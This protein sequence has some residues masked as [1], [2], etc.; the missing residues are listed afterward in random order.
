[1]AAAA[2]AAILGGAQAAGGII[3]SVLNYFNVLH[4]NESNEKIAA[5]NREFQHNEA[6]IDREWQTNMS[7]TAYQRSMADMQAAGLN[8]NLL[9]PSS[10]QVGN[11]GV[12]Q[13][14]TATMQ[15]PK[16]ENFLNGLTSALNAYNTSKL[17]ESMDAK[18]QA[19][20]ILKSSQDDLNR[21]L[22]SYRENK[23]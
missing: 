10:A 16:F 23:Y 9:S 6:A 3:S 12:P 17:I 21:Q 20:I 2:A 18:N 11:V 7:N 13:G 22:W 5:E 15:A 14:S 19:D 1:M 8:P 4:A